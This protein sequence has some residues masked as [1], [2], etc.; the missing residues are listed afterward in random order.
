MDCSSQ[1][2]VEA[3]QAP[4]TTDHLYDDVPEPALATEFVLF[5]E[6]DDDLRERAASN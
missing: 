4:T 1:Y 5:V 6:D 2:G 3:V